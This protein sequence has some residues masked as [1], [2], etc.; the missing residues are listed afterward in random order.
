ML[1]FIS[2]LFDWLFLRL[3]SQEKLRRSDESEGEWDRKSSKIL[4][5]CIFLRK[6]NQLMT[7]TSIVIRTW[8]KKSLLISW[9][10]KLVWSSWEPVFGYGTN[11]LFVKNYVIMSTQSTV[12]DYAFNLTRNEFSTKV[13]TNLINDEKIGQNWQL[14]KNSESRF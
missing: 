11:K 2:S 5:I 3:F 4:E 6:S 12:A 9:K 8:N 13:W 1:I 7:I 14:V 10:I